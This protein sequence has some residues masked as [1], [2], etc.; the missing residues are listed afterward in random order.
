[1]MR[2]ATCLYDVLTHYEDAWWEKWK[3]E[4]AK[5]IFD[6]VRIAGK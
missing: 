2:D 1:V 3:T 5:R 6:T 4:K